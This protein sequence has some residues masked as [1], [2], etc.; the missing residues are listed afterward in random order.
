MLKL[1]NLLEGLTEFTGSGYTHGHGLLW[2][3]KYKLKSTKGETHRQSPEKS[4]SGAS[5][6]HLSVESWR[7]LTSQQWYETTRVKYCQP[8]KVTRAL[9]SRIL[10][11]A[12]SLKPIWPPKW[13]PSVSMPSGGQLIS[14]DPKPPPSITLLMWL[15]ATMLS[16]VVIV[17]LAQGTQVSKDTFIKAAHSKGLEVTSQE[18]RAK[19]RPFFG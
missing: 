9:A 19:I 10:A 15:K 8:W 13:L 5:I 11:G 6:C 16:Y 1:H 2:G 18:T 17:W 4:K 12:W 7:T 14:C 3:K